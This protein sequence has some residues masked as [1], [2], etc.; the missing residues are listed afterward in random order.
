MK[1]NRQ[2]NN[3]QDTRSSY[4]L[5]LPPVLVV[6]CLAAASFYGLILSGP[7]DLEI[8]RRYCLSHP[9]AIASVSLFCI[10]MSSLLY[11]WYQAT[12]QLKLAGKAATALKRLTTD[13]DDIAPA[14][15]PNWL[16]ANLQALPAN[17]QQ[18]WFGARVKRVL[19]LQIQRGRRSQLESDL[20]S[21]NEADA[22]QQ[23]ESLSLLRIINWAMP[24]LGFL[25]T[26]LGISKTLGQLDTKMLASDSQE[27]MNQLT[28]GLYVA[29][30]TTAIALVLTVISMFIQFG[31]SRLE[32][33]LLSRIDRDSGDTLVGF[34][35]VDPTDSQ[36][37]LLAPVREM[38]SEL[39]NVIQG[40]VETQAAVWARTISESQR[41]WRQWAENTCELAENQLGEKLGE[42]LDVHAE[43]LRN[44]NEES[45][46]LADR[47]AQQWQTT[48]SDQAR[49]AQAQQREISKQTEA[50]YDQTQ[51]LKALVEQTTQVKKL[52]E[53]IEESVGRL[54][55][56]GRIEKA[57]LCVGEAVAVLA[58]SLERSGVLRTPTRPRP[59]RGS[60]ESDS[61][62]TAAFGVVKAEQDA[63]TKRKAA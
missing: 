43:K 42:Q 34:I 12:Q 28:A 14:Q 25:G 39:V 1:Q 17:L 38:T 56:V 48:L 46:G 33:N 49:L 23:H 2:S 31:V 51:T 21:L 47:R 36:T 40:L 11:K 60:S 29:F 30:D 53:V 7:L 22:D 27:A 55:N 62:D 59:K 44:I 9:V 52:E 16:S 13:G 4:A 35:G 6:G 58:T 57:T 19:E 61:S 10:G 24:M 54:E 5:P 26:V 20:H 18:S 50:L 32:T 45:N 15:R 3:R 37:A 8:L 41:Q 63:P